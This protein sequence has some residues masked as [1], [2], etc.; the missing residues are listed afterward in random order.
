VYLAT[1]V[2]AKKLTRFTGLKQRNFTLSLDEQRSGLGDFDQKQAPQL[3]CFEVDGE[4]GETDFARVRG[5]PRLLVSERAMQTLQQFN[6]GHARIEP[7]DPD[8][9]NRK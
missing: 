6:L 3:V 8:V 5:V 2:L 4:L 9:A 1:E 7:F